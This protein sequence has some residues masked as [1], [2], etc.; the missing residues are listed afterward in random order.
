MKKAFLA[1]SYSHK[2]ELQEEIASIVR[3]LKQLSIKTIVFVNKY[4]FTLEREKEMMRI[5]F[6]E[7]RDSDIVIAEASNRA[8]GVGVEIGY[9]KSFNKPIVYVRKESAEYS[10][11]VGGVSDLKLV[12]KNVKDLEQKLFHLFFNVFTP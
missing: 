3:I 10:S 1:V 12:Y 6:E 4:S 5:A 2:D 11:V 8:I 9:A 7:I